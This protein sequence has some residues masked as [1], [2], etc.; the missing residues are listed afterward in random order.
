MS[1]EFAIRSVR[2]EPY[3]AVPTLLFRLAIGSQHP[4]STLSLRCQVQ[5]EP[6]KRPYTK[7]EQDRLLELFGEPPRW[8]QTQK[9]V[10]WAHLNQTVPAFD[11]S[12][13]VDL[14]MPCTY[15]FEVAA[16]KY[17]HALDMGDIPLV[18]LFSGSLFRRGQ[19][20]M[21]IEPIAWDRECQFRLP[22]SLW[23]ELMDAYYPGGGWIRLSRESLDALQRFKAERALVNWDETV[24]TLL[25]GR[26]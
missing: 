7:V 11:Q 10:L 2:V 15:D 3:A 12:T 26:V 6:R 17:F 24:L 18:L 5:I 13:E 8:A 22:V 25:G 1:L 21:L 4:V 19:Q 23:R 9:N 16:V 14:V 20:G